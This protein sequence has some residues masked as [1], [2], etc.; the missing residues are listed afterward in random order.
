M[1]YQWLST[2]Q[3]L[4]DLL[5]VYNAKALKRFIN[6][7]LLICHQIFEPISYKRTFK[8]KFLI[9]NHLNFMNNDWVKM[10]CVQQQNGLHGR[11]VQLLVVPVSGS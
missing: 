7:N 5:S 9:S 8:I 11:T 10:T 3:A 1:K 2:K 6:S 4:I